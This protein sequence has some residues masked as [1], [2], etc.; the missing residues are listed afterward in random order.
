VRSKSDEDEG[1]SYTWAPATLPTGQP[2]LD[3]D[4]EQGRSYLPLMGS[5]LLEAEVPSSDQLVCAEV[6]GLLELM[7]SAAPCQQYDISIA[8]AVHKVCKFLS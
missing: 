2:L 6:L 3:E 7:L 5:L 8:C 1:L 4:N